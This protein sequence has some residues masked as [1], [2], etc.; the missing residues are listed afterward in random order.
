MAP[1]SGAH[2]FK[3]NFFGGN[4]MIKLLRNESGNIAMVQAGIY[5]IV[6]L[7]VLYIG[8]TINQNV[9][10][11]ADFDDSVEATGVVTFT[12]VGVADEVINI[13]TETYTMKAAAAGE[14]QVTIGASAAESMTNLVAEITANSTLL[15][16][17]STDGVGTVTA[18]VVGVAGNEYAFT[19][20]VTGG[21]VDAATLTGGSDADALYTASTEM[22]STTESAYGMA[23]I[24]PIVM[25]AVAILASLLGIVYLFR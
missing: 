2:F 20:D 15:S 22:D 25:I 10:D 24:M 8:L 1:E 5:L 16:A 18:L 3:Q 11:A 9:I 7:V 21:S 23:S 4:H 6:L 17:E 19:T 13:S 12:G 14:Y